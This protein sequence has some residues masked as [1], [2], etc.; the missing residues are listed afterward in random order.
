ML[1]LH[2]CCIGTAL[3]AAVCK[4][5]FASAP[6]TVA[7]LSALSCACAAATAIARFASRFSL[8]TTLL[9]LWFP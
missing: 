5:E 4:V 7:P 6:P 3:C 9:S 8:I 1:M 2:W